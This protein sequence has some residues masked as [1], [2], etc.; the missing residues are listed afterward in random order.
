MGA[1]VLPLPHP[2]RQPTLSTGVVAALNAEAR[3][4]GALRR[5]GDGLGVTT[6]GVLVA[7]SGIGGS[8]AADA[9][10]RLAD[11]GAT[12]LVSWGLAGGLDPS[13]AAGTICLPEFITA[14]GS[15]VFS[16]DHHWRELVAAAIAARRTVVNGALFSS[17]RSIDAV[18]AKAAAFRETG[19]AA[20]DMESHAIAAVAA[21]R[22]LPFIAVRVIV[23]TAGDSLPD[24][25]LAA[26]AGGQVRLPRLLQG[27]ARA[28]GDVA[29]LLRLALRYRSARQAL[30]AVA[31]S[32][33]LAPLAF[34]ATHAS[35]IA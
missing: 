5:R 26:S 2:A 19:A 29:P 7:V 28:P 10:E 9:A 23:D 17:E 31:R 35:R 13:L 14:A 11:A 18:V 15:T 33:A 4:L 32:G 34:A 1:R 30:V 12:S 25:V 22:A 3:T 20:V 27:L 16:T 6:E 21:A 24:A 8:P